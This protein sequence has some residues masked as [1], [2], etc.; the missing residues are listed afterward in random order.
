MTGRV[1]LNRVEFNRASLALRKVGFTVV[2][3]VTFNTNIGKSWDEC[4]RYDLRRMLTCNG[5]A[6][7][8]DW[9]LSPGARLECSTASAVGLPVRRYLDWVHRAEQS[10]LPKEI[11]L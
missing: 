11:T 6:V 4:L 3:P 9:S 1:D 10:F 8:D 5:V 7:L 2:N